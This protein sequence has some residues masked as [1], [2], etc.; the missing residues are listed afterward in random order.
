MNDEVIFVP[1]EDRVLVAREE[2][3]VIYVPAEWREI[4]V[5]NDTSGE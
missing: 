2:E 1:E 4:E 5:P 3:W